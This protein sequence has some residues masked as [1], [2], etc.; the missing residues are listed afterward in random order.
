MTRHD[1]W[2]RGE[3]S[4]LESKQKTVPFS[5]ASEIVCWKA[6]KSDGGIMNWIIFSA[7]RLS[8]GRYRHVGRLHARCKK[9]FSES[10]NVLLHWCDSRFF[11]VLPAKPINPTRWVYFTQKSD[12]LSC[13]P[14][15]SER[16]HCFCVALALFKVGDFIEGNKHG[17]KKSETIWKPV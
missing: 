15:S 17:M 16:L 4:E 2:Y 6:C 3:G 13:V 7:G 11:C 5:I 9:A 8:L 10:L 12:P 14:D 1:F